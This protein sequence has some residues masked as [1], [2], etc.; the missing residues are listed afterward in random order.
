MELEIQNKTKNVK[1]FSKKN[2]WDC[3]FF[4]RTISGGLFNK[5]ELPFIE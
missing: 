3:Y 2:Y 1:F 4:W 5:R